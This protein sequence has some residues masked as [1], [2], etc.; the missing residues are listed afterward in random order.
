SAAVAGA[1]EASRYALAAG[2]REWSSSPEIHADFVADMNPAVDQILIDT[3]QSHSRQG[4]DTGAEALAL[5]QT[6]WSIHM[7]DGERTDLEDGEFFALFQRVIDSSS[8]RF[9]Q[10][11]DERAA[12][13]TG[14][15]TLLETIR[16]EDSA[17]AEAMA[18][19]SQLRVALSTR[20]N[21]AF[22]RG[23]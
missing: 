11:D 20:V 21:E 13:M 3:I 19:W 9:I 5:L 16:P 4:F 8:D 22:R 10:R 6:A 18:A 15:I 7:T 12:F 14:M 1:P 2:Y 23:L 17:D